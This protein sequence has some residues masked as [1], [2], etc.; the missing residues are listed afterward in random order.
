[1]LNLRE[2]AECVNQASTAGSPGDFQAA[3]N[4]AVYNTE[5]AKAQKAAEDAATADLV[6]RMGRGTMV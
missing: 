6:D 1:M 5:A 2:F 4:T 3:L